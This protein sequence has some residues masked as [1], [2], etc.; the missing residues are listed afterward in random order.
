MVD[1]K[2]LDPF[3]YFDRWWNKYVGVGGPIKLVADIL[4]AIIFM[5]ALYLVLSIILN[6]PR[7][8][9]IVASSS[10]EPILYPGDVVFIR[11]IDPTTVEVKEVEVNSSLNY[12]VTPAD[13]NIRFVRE[14]LHLKYIEV[15]GVVLS[16]DRGPIVVYYD[17]IRGRD[18]IHRVILK[19][20]AKDE[21]LFITKGDNDETNPTADQ[22][23]VL[24]RCV[25]PFLVSE[26]QILGTPFFVVPRIGI[27]KVLLFG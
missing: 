13:L 24:G 16:P 2:R 19:I 7:P 23:C 17:D 14:G 8:I 18:I 21:Y 5:S 25:Y 26:K 27:I 10:M 4:F 6:T 11:G 15:N 1:L 22:D 3:Y 9:I 20:R 12:R